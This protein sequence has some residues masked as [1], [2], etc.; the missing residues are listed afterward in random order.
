MNITVYQYPYLPITILLSIGPHYV[1]V[2]YKEEMS[3]YMNI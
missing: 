3:S 1:A 2:N